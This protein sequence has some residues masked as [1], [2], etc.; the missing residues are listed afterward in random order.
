MIT[1]ASWRDHVGHTYWIE[2]RA[3]G[4]GHPPDHAGP[5][6]IIGDGL[7]WY[8]VGSL[9]SEGRSKDKYDLVL[10]GAVPLEN[11][12]QH[13]RPPH[14]RE[15]LPDLFPELAVH[16]IQRVLAELHMTAERPLKQLP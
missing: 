2:G 7:L 10:C 13:A 11:V 14:S 8:V 12:L 1:I 15:R 9:I 16:S 6:V 5:A 4:P 3:G